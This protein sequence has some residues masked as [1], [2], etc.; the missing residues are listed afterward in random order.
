MASPPSQ[1]L[2]G[3]EKS[4]EGKPSPRVGLSHGDVRRS[5]VKVP[6]AVCVIWEATGA[7]PLAA[8]HTVAIP[9]P[10]HD[11]PELSA[12]FPGPLELALTP[13]R[14]RTVP[15]RARTRPATMPPRCSLTRQT[16]RY[17]VSAC[18]STRAAPA[19]GEERGRLQ[20]AQH[21]DL[22]KH[23]LGPHGAHAQQHALARHEVAG[24][25]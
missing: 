13:Q 3:W 2:R 10:R 6:E 7:R 12:W 8:V 23:K 14:A 16:R 20:R 4:E 18:F 1:Y 25:S 21:P 15:A 22:N 24:L 9:A 19:T 5:T 17:Q 11:E